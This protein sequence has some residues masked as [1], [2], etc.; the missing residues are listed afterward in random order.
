MKRE[1]E[2]AVLRILLICMLLLASAPA[3]AQAPYDPQRA[4]HPV[5]IVAYVVHPVGWLLDRLIFFPAWWIG[6]HEPLR[7]IFGHEGL[8]GE[9]VEVVRAPAPEPLPQPVPAD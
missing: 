6:G 7:S 3:R 1:E 8:P 2:A 4:G 5:R 9:R